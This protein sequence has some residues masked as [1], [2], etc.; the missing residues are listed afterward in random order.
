[1]ASAEREL[2]EMIKGLDPDQLRGFCAKREGFRWVFTIP[3]ALHQNGCAEALVNS[4]KNSQ[5]KAIDES[6]LRS[7]CALACSVEN[8]NRDTQ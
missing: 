2:R 6:R 5:K 7:S 3:A 1:M 4:S 8:G